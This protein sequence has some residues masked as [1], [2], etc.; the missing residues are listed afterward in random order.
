MF[1]SLYITN[2]NNVFSEYNKTLIKIAIFTLIV[3][4]TV[5]NIALVNCE[6]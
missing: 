1:S 4:I 6:R 3:T 5:Y 2:S